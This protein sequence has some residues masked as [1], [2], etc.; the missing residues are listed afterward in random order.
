MTRPIFYVSDSTAMTAKGLG[1]SLLSQFDNLLIMEHLRP[2]VDSPQKV[3]ELI[4]EIESLKPV[5]AIEV[6]KTSLFM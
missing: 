4:E 3:R 2:Y 1:K 6:V 5:K